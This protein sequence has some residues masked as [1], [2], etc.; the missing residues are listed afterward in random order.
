MTRSKETAY[1]WLLRHVA[2]AGDDCL[3]WPFSRCA[4]HGRGQ[5]GYNGKRSIAAH[6]LMCE[7]AHG[8]K[9]TPKH[10]ASHSCGNGHLGCVNPRHLSWATN[11]QNQLD[12]RRHGTAKAGNPNGRKGKLTA[13]QVARIKALKGVRTQLELA[14]MFGVKYGTIGSI[15]RG[16]TWGHVAPYAW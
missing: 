8:T 9:P 4:P 1:D 13:E 3:T 11:S 12:R 15:H 2:Y 5:L 7:L 14:E 16:E 6:R 10:Q